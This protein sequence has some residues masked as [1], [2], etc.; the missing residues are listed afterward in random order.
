MARQRKRSGST[1]AIVGVLALAVGLAGS[2]PTL[3]QGAAPIR[4]GTV[5]I[6]LSNVDTGLYA[7]RFRAHR[8][9][10]GRTLNLAHDTTCC[11]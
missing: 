3:V 2:S 8:R 5:A 1:W 11:V 10:P 7:P 4:I 9:P 6:R